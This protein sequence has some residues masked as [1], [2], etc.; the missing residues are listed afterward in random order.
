[1]FSFA[2]R[3]SLAAAVLL[4]VVGC[5]RRS[6]DVRLAPVEDPDPFSGTIT[7]PGTAGTAGTEGSTETGSGTPTGSTGGTTGGTGST[8]GTT[9]APVAGQVCFPGAL[10]DWSACLDT[11]AL[12]P[13][14]AEYVYPAPLGGSPQ[15]LEPVLYFDLAVEDPL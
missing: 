7:E 6:A 2:P 10:Y 15:Y 1:M 8:G 11:V 13:V 4:T 14:P 9:P 12:S 3:A 5:G